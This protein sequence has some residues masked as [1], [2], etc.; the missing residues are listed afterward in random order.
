MTVKAITP[1]RNLNLVA[2]LA[3]EA[4]DMHATDTAACARA[5]SGAASPLIGDSLQSRLEKVT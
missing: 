3:H 2:P 4:T 5:R 1:V